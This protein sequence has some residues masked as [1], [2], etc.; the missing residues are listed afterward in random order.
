MPTRRFSVPD[1]LPSGEQR[2]HRHA[3]KWMGG[4]SVLPPQTRSGIERTSGSETAATELE[5]TPDLEMSDLQWVQAVEEGLPT[6]AVESAVDKGVV[7]WSDVRGLVLPRRTFSRR[8]ERSGRL[9]PEESDRLLR[10]L[11]T[12]ARAEETF[13]N[14]EKARRW[15]RKPNRALEGEAPLEMLQTASGARLVEQ[16]LGRIAHGVYS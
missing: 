7:S 8:K 3:L 9:K 11:R 5:E 1:D 14:E 2:W 6:E 4:P 15:I 10:L 16:V 12:I 13:G